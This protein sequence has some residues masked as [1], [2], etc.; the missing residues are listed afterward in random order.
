MDPME[1]FKPFS[2]EELNIK[3]KLS[4]TRYYLLDRMDYKTTVDFYEKIVG[5]INDMDLHISRNNIQVNDVM[6]G[7]FTSWEIAIEKIMDVLKRDENKLSE[8]FDAIWENVTKKKN[9]TRDSHRF[10]ILS[11]AINSC[12]VASYFAE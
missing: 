1:I 8:L 5:R 4:I 12:Y 9:F 11:P 7:S 6:A 3:Q 10:C 2:K